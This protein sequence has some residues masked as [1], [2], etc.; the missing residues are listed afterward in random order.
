M[1]LTTERLRLREI[2]AEDW[3]AVLAY[4]S[5]PLYL[6][7][8]PWEERTPEAVRAFLGRFIDQQHDLP[9]TMFHLAITRR[10]DGELIG[11]AGLRRKDIGAW[12]AEIGY[13]LAPWEWGKGYATETA[14][15]LLSYGFGE[16]RLHRIWANCVAENTASAHVLEKIG[17]TLEG[18]LRQAEWY[19]DR[20]W[21]TLLYA[22]LED[23]WKSKESK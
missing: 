16:F 21:D 2:T 23:E 5:D 7:Y 1:E 4:Q 3:P 12:T 11:L 20:W 14:R 13:E 22:I 18:R 8:N 6:R 15:Y 19:K 17:M 10:A 9:R